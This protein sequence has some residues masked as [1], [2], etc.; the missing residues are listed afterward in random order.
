MSPDFVAAKSKNAY[1]TKNH[2]LHVFLFCSSYLVVSNMLA[3]LSEAIYGFPVLSKD[4]SF[5]RFY[6]YPGSCLS[7]IHRTFSSLYCVWVLACN[8]TVTLKKLVLLTLRCNLKLV[9][10]NCWYLDASTGSSGHGAVSPSLRSKRGAW[11]TFHHSLPPLSPWADLHIW[12][13]SGWG[14]TTENSYLM[15]E[16]C[17]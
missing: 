16:R 10:C 15:H 13:G 17:V 8:I 7:L 12:W 3:W 1:G 2:T 14:R 9:S 6:N 5:L 4:S 11:D